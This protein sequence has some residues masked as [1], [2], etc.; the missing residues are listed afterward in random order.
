MHLLIGFLRAG[1]SVGSLDLDARQGTLSTY[2][3]NRAKY[4]SGSACRCRCRHLQAIQLTGQEA[5][6]RNRLDDGVQSLLE[7]CDLVLIDTPGADN[8]L[9]RAGHA[10][11]DILVTPLERQLHRS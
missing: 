9:S 8:H 4:A 7:E 5:G 1:F 11:A 3:A 10:W 6:D 2:V